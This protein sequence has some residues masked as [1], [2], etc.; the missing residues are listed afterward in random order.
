MTAGEIISLVSVSL[1][2]VTT[3]LGGLMWVIKAQVTAMRKDLQ[4][5]GGSS[6]KDQLNRIESDVRDV[7]MKVDDHIDWHMDNSR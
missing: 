5:N 1:A 2:I 4:P 3:L 7:R 6:V